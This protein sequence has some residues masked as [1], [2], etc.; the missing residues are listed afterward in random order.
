MNL[1]FKF[2]LLFLFVIQ[3]QACG[4]QNEIISNPLAQEKPLR[5]SEPVDSVVADLRTYIPERMKGSNV[6][7]VSIA[8]IRD[9]QI[10]WTDGFG[11]ANHFSKRQMSPEAVFEV[12]SISKTITA[13]I[14]LRLLEHGEL[15]LDEPVHR[16]LTKKWV[17]SSERA[18]KIT[19]RHLLSHTSGLG[20]DVF[21]KNKDVTF[22]PG[23]D[24]LYSGLG[25]LYVQELIEQVTGKSLEQ[26]AHE[27]VFE[28]LGMS[29]SSFVNETGVMTYMANGHLRYTLPLMAFLLPFLLITMIVSIIILIMIRIIKKS[30]KLSGHV[31]V[32]VA[33]IAFI[34]TE[35]LIYFVMGLP[36]PNLVWVS[37]ICGV[38]FIAAM[39][40]CYLIVRKL[41]S[42]I[43]A[44]D[45]KKTLRTMVTTIWIIASLLV[46]LKISEF[47]K[48]PIPKNN[49]IEAS[50]IGS[51]RST[52]LDLATFL[53]ELANPQY[54]SKEIAFQVNSAQ[55]S[56]DQNFSWGLGIGIQHS[57]AGNALWQ[58]GI[59]FAYR[60]IMIIYPKKGH[61]VVVLTNSESGLPVACDIAERALGGKALWKYF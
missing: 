4:Q 33:V 5:T 40:L 48:A 42:L 12:A 2:F 1:Y 32:G 53:I 57:D 29:R 43:S 25:F 3:I 35:L 9:H 41:M 60:S 14:A 8:F 50:A 15:S 54:L 52:A 11:V 47:I 18:D 34:L 19:L 58:N 16:Y 46:L 23:S 7:G 28:P 44:L 56:I 30:W 59:T 51:L 22:E 27:L 24:F 39:L 31:K 61:G 21:F 37:F 45:Q 20:D 38:V 10:V 13:Y 26:V 49:S 36:F 6:P 55:V 17:P